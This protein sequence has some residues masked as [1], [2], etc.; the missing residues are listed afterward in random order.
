MPRD[1]AERFAKQYGE[2]L[3]SCQDPEKVDAFL[4]TLEAEAQQAGDGEAA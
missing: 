4:R 3:P 2:P 1:I